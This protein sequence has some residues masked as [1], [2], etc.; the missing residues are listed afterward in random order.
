MYGKE[1]WPGAKEITSK[2]SKTVSLFELKGAVYKTTR[3]SP[4]EQKLKNYRGKKKKKE[5][6]WRDACNYF[7]PLLQRKLLVLRNQLLIKYMI[8]C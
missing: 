8:Y 6:P 2:V 5:L 7:A 1:V 4:R 3:D